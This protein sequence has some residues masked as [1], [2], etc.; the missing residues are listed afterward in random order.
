M[1]GRAIITKLSEKDLRHLLR[2]TD[3]TFGPLGS[4]GYSVRETR[5]DANVF[6]LSELDCAPSRTL[7]AFIDGGT[8]YA[9]KAAEIITSTFTRKGLTFRVQGDVLIPPEIRVR[10]ERVATLQGKRIA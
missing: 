6:T 2:Q 3:N 4:G 10:L 5:E 8:V 9:N 7:L 1:N